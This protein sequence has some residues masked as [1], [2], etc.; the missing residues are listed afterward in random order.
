LLRSL[1]LLPLWYFEYIVYLCCSVDVF[2][3]FDFVFSSTGTIVP[4]IK[5]IH[6]GC[7]MNNTTIDNYFY[8]CSINGMLPLLKQ[9]SSSG[10]QISLDGIGL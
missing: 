1:L 5:I 6:T 4:K 9:A 10:M 3:S 7:L 2:G 8:I